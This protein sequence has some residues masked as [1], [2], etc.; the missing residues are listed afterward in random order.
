MY[1]EIEIR[2]ALTSKTNEV[3]C[4]SILINVLNGVVTCISAEQAVRVV[5]TIAKFIEFSSSLT[6]NAEAT[7]SEVQD[8]F[9]IARPIAHPCLDTRCVNK[10]ELHSASPSY[11]SNIV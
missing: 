8:P 11:V 6:Y 5:V 7:A 4:Y 1:L 3:F 10:A 2:E 9:K